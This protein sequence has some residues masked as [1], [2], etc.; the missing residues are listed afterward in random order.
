MADLDDALEKIERLTAALEQHTKPWTSS[1]H[2][3]R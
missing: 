2:V 3:L 1:R